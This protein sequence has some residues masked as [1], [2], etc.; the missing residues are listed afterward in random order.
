MVKLMD[1]ED[2]DE[3]LTFIFL[4]HNQMIQSEV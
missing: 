3:D 1:L 4:N 2:D